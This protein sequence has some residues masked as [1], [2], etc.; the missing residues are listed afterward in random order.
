M[1][2]HSPIPA[3]PRRL[4][5][6]CFHGSPP[7]SAL[8]TSFRDS[9]W[10]TEQGLPGVKGQDLPRHTWSSLQ[11]SFRVMGIISSDGRAGDNVLSWVSWQQHL[12][13]E[14]ET[15]RKMRVLR[16]LWQEP[17]WPY[18][19]MQQRLG[20][21]SQNSLD[22]FLRMLKDQFM[23]LVSKVF[24]LNLIIAA[25][26]WFPFQWHFSTFPP[27]PSFEHIFCVLQT[28]YISLSFLAGPIFSHSDIW[29]SS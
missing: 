2:D 13:W 9:L 17:K 24:T 28:N 16:I 19:A 21:T 27:G 1:T 29:L 4:E 23:A 6:L 14:L 8:L 22:S 5:H 26:Q 20:A 15:L 12:G 18:W 25:L 10:T 11:L 3:S 7:L